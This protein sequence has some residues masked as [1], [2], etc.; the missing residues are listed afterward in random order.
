MESGILEKGDYVY[1]LQPDGSLEEDKIIDLIR[2]E[3]DFLT[4]TLVNMKYGTFFADDIVVHNC[5]MPGTNINLANDSKKS[6]EDVEVGDIIKVFNE[7]NQ[8]I[9]DAPV[10]GTRTTIADDLYE[11]YLDDG[12]L[13]M[14]TSTHPF[15]TNEK[16]WATIIGDDEK[17]VETR[18]LEI[19][20]YLYSLESDGILEE[21]Q[22]VD[23]VAID[24][25]YLVYNFM[26]MEYE[27]YFADDII[28]HNFCFMPGT[29][30]NLANGTYKNI[31]DIQVG[32]EVKV[33]NE[34][35]QIIENVS[36]NSFQRT[37]QNNIF[38]LFLDNGK[39]LQPTANHPFLTKEKGWA[40]ISGLDEM[41]VDS[42]ALE[43]GDYL[44]S[45]NSD[46]E[47]EETKV[48]DIVPVEGEYLTYN[49]VDMETGTYLADDIV[50][51]NCECFLPGTP[52]SM[53]DGTF[54][55]IERIEIGEMVKVF[56][57]ATK[58]VEIAPA[59]DLVL[60]TIHDDVH[61]VYFENGVMLKPGSDHPFLTKGKGWASVNGLDNLEIGADKLEIDDYVYYQNLDGSLEWV[62]VS[63]IIPIEGAYATFDLVNMKYGTFLAGNFVV[64]N[65]FLPGSQ[66]S[67]GDGSY[68]N[69]EDIEIGDIVKV[70]KEGT[71]TIGETTANNIQK[72]IKDDIYE[73]HLENGNILRQ[74]ATHPFQTI[75][76]QWVTISG[77]DGSSEYCEILEIGDHITQ[78]NTDGDIEYVQVI[79]I[80][81]IEGV[82][83][84][85]TFLD[86]ISAGTHVMLI[87]GTNKNI[88]DL[89]I[90]DI[91][92]SIDFETSLE[93]Y[94]GF[95]DF[96]EQELKA[97]LP[98]YTSKN[99]T[100]N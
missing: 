59:N 85:Y 96:Y 38:E 93:N 97:I 24:G 89:E 42:G 19:G 43:K 4:Y 36:V 57:E 52:V 45:L 79:D 40:T 54:K 100:N 11:L 55:D 65:C 1:S 47:L 62:R 44:Y 26:D 56:N 31:E 53:A 13:L 69:I 9:E 88:E 77:L 78:L 46:G 76:N 12:T 58:E 70:F 16:E 32:D 91:I 2:I 71:T 10:T 8:T 67:M 20:D 81:P 68:K 99:S 34:E 7:E 83:E 92:F 84:M 17:G 39:I 5:F 41:G 48:I 18:K 25:E 80:I 75:E 98:Q 15:Y 30:I 66:I 63:N 86:G 27:T 50:T 87:D 64:H 33:Y 37:L 14:V 21:V 51:H 72:I 90:G 28:T 29:Q 61:E 22:V 95:D 94:R 60:V 6:I 73:I 82:F 49:L 3:G 74:T 35:K 23:I